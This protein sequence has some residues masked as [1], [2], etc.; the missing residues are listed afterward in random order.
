MWAP[1]AAL[2]LL[3]LVLAV[4][5]AS[6]WLEFVPP[7]SAPADSHP[8]SRLDS[9]GSRLAV[10]GCG[11]DYDHADRTRL[12]RRNRYFP[13]GSPLFLTFLG[14]QIRIDIHPRQSRLGPVMM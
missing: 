1:A 9:L 2:L 8:L 4:P 10:P 14:R 5:G 6:H 7:A 11:G 12:N 3:S 13:A